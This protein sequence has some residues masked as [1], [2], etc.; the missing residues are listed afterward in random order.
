MPD[1]EAQAHEAQRWLVRAWEE[2]SVAE[3][4]AANADLP[5]RVACFHAQQAAEKAL[6]AALVHDAI[7]FPRTH[8]LEQLVQALP[9]RW[10]VRKVNADL[11]WLSR[12]AVAARYPASGSDASAD[13]AARATLAARSIVSAV[14]ADA[15]PRA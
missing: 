9:A 10:S 13:D 4:L 1:S 8:D 7:R 2:L 6:K 3:L 5:P 14:S 12:W 11:A 15:E